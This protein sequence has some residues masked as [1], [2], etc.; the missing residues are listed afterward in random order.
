MARGGAGAATLDV[1]D[2]AGRKVASV[3]PIAD[4]NGVHWSWDGRAATGER[5]V[6]TVLFA[7]ARDG[8]GGVARIVRLP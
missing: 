7:R 2:V 4:A 1:F 5:I 3:E 6:A 8:R